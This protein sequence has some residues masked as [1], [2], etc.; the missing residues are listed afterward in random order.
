MQWLKK[1]RNNSYLKYKRKAELNQG[2]DLDK[3]LKMGVF[4]MALEGIHPHFFKNN[5]LRETAEHLI[6]F[7]LRLD[8]SENFE[9]SKIKIKPEDLDKIFENFE[10]RIEQRLPVE[11]ITQEAWY[12]GNFFHVNPHV[13]IPRSIMATRFEDFLS[14][15][16]WQNYRVLD[17]C[18]GS[19]CIGISL[20]LM[21][22][23]LKIDLL[24]ISEAALAIAQKNINYYNL[25]DRVKIIQS[26]L[27]ENLNPENPGQQYDFIIS[28]PPYVPMSEYQKIPAEFKQEPKMALEAG[29]DGLNIIDKIL[30]QAG[31][32]LN[33]TGQL[34]VET[35]FTTAKK[36]KKKYKHLNLSWFKYRHP[37]GKESIWGMDGIFKCPA[38]NL[39]T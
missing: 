37:Q 9:L 25:Q 26:N 6:K 31:N 7:S 4:W 27:F 39:K 12:F 29:I 2:I 21:H 5:T 18:T 17:L 14:E 1:L 32:F 19:G 28:N 38:Q 23:K 8:K 10:K 13:L 15:I 34:I 35:G 3:I 36:I 24:D 20:A 11:Y 33:P 30:E 16:Q 22:P